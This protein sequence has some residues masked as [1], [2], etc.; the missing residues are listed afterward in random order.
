MWRR[1]YGDKIRNLRATESSG[2][3]AV[4]LIVR[5]S[6][7]KTMKNRKLTKEEIERDEEYDK[8][9]EEME[10]WQFQEHIK[11]CRDCQRIIVKM[12]IDKL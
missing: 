8:V 4:A 11:K 10:C 3:L 7:K 1:M 9:M 6:L 5:Y 12:L 2:R